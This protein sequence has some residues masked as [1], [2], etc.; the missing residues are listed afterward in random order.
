MT[1]LN[2]KPM[3][4]SA[5]APVEEHFTN[6]PDGLRKWL[7]DRA[8]AWIGFIRTHQQLLRSLDAD[9]AN[10]HGITL[11]AFEVLARVASGPEGGERITVLAEQAM[12]SQSRV[13]RLVDQLAARGLVT[14]EPCATDSRVVHVVITPAGK[15]LMREA[16][17][18]HFDGV[19]E[20]FFGKLSCTEIAQLASIFAKL[21]TPDGTC[22][23]VIDTSAGN[24]AK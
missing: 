13:S 3:A 4:R 21:S 1:A 2:W 14:R 20:R 9:L 12:L 6:T 18:T 22:D 5:P 11:S 7:P 10:R 8:D 15:E 16:Q 19:E 24:G 17:A 23:V